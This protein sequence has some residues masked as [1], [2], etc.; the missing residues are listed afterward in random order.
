MDTSKALNGLGEA[1]DMPQTPNY[2]L[3]C[4]SQSTR[5]AYQCDW[6]HFTKWCQSHNLEPL[7]AT[8]KTIALYLTDMAQLFKPI[9]LT[10][11]LASISVMHQQT[12]YSSPTGNILVRDTLSGIRRHHGTAQTRKA[13]I[14]A[15]NI[16][17][18]IDVIPN[19]LRGLRDKALL[20]I[21]Y[22]GALRRSELAALDAED[23]VL[24][25]Q[26][27]RLTIRHS[28]TDQEGQGVVMGIGYG[29]NPSTCPVRA[30]MSWIEAAKISS[31]PLF[32]PV[33]GHSQIGTTRLCNRTIALII[34]GLALK[35]G[36]DPKAISGHS[37][38]AG[39]I[40]DQYAAGTA[41]ALI[42]A[43]S[44]HKS[45]SVMAAYRREADMFAFDYAGVAGL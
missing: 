7:P 42:M 6:T 37:L 12:D 34:K 44:R 24:V 2:I 26:G 14:R 3:S 41:E 17:R 15:S 43:R 8:P 32:R 33:R 36:L 25:D 27:I 22:T 10:R 11:R 40:T 19:D 31:G 45:H 4:R 13:P 5:K 39:F 23:V 29:A 20:L 35:L 1:F 28:K 16:C 21:G 38:R 9:T 30:L 18:A